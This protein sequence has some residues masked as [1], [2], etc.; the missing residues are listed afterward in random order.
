MNRTKIP[1]FR[2]LLGLLILSSCIGCDQATKTIATRT[3]HNVPP[4]SYLAD[5]IRIHLALNPG[6][7]L[8]L[9]STL[10]ANVRMSVFLGFNSCIMLG[11]VTFL[12]LKRDIRMALFLSL[13]FI[14]AGNIGNMIDRLSNHGLVTDFLNVGI[15]PVRTGIFNVADMAVLFGAIAVGCLSFQGDGDIQGVAHK[16]Q[17]EPD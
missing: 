8:S 13:V 10:P 2:M 9:G 12:L 4:K 16:R 17:S 5:T 14:L 1:R 15:G 11:L 3:L 6:G 7:F